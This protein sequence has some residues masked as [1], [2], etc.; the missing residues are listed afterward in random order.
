MTTGV[1]YCATA[2]QR[3]DLLDAFPWVGELSLIVIRRT[4]GECPSHDR[5]GRLM[6]TFHRAFYRWSSRR[7]TRG[8]SR[9]RRAC[10]QGV[11]E[12]CARSAREIDP[13]LGLSR[14]WDTGL[15]ADDAVAFAG[16]WAAH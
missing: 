14:R 9:Q 11:M 3:A 1:C 8:P 10:A 6:A 15:W 5:A 7:A 2:G 13:R 16:L 12:F 4:S